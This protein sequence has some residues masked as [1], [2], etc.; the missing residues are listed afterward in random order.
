MSLFIQYPRLKCCYVPKTP[1]CHGQIFPWEWYAHAYFFLRQ[2][3]TVAEEKC[4]KC[5]LRTG[6]SYLCTLLSNNIK[7][8]TDLSRAQEGFLSACKIQPWNRNSS[9]CFAMSCLSIWKLWKQ[10]LK[11]RWIH[12]QRLQSIFF[13]IYKFCLWNENAYPLGAITYHTSLGKQW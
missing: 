12:K 1:P 11:R 5:L 4:Q 2:S 9:K 3:I 6:R 13:S 8:L 7:A 10:S